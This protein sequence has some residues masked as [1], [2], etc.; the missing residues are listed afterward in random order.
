IQLPRP[1]GGQA[2]PGAGQI[3]IEFAEVAGADKARQALSG[4]KY[5]GNPVKASFYP[6]DLFQVR[7]WL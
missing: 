3:F 5:S 7:V 6:L 2:V 1:L 4:R